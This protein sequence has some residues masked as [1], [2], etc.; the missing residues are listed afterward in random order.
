MKKKI[1]LSL[2]I[3]ALL[4]NL[5]VRVT[6][7]ADQ[8][9]VFYIRHEHIG[10]R[11]ECGGCYTVPHY[12]VHCEPGEG[13]CYDPVYHSHTGSSSRGGGCYTA[14]VP[15]HHSGNSSSGGA[16]YSP[17]YHS[18]G[19]SCYT[20]HWCTV[21][22][23]TQELITTYTGPCGIHGDNATYVKYK[24]LERHYNC[25][26]GDIWSEVDFCSQCGAPGS[27]TSHEYSELI[28]TKGSGT[29]DSYRLSCGHSEGDVDHY[30]I[31]CGLEG[32]IV[33]YTL[34]CTKGA[35]YV[36]CYDRGCGIEEGGNAASVTVT[37]TL[38]SGGEQASLTA[39]VN[40]LT[41]GL[42][43]L[44]NVTLV[45]KDEG[46]NVIGEGL[47]LT[48]DENGTY[49][50]TAE[51]S[52]DGI[53][54]DT[55]SGNVTVSGIEKIVP[56]GPDEGTSGEENTQNGDDNPV[57]D[58]GDDYTGND[59]DT[60]T[61]E[62][63]GN[64][65]GEQND[66]S[67]NEDDEYVLPFPTPTPTATPVVA[68]KPGPGDKGSSHDTNSASKWNNDQGNDNA[69]SLRIGLMS[70]RG[71]ETIKTDGKIRAVK[72]EVPAKTSDASN[73]EGLSADTL[74]DEGAGNGFLGKAGVF[75]RSP[76]GK[77][78]TIGLST[79]LL[80]AALF[81]LLL[82]LRVT[83][84]VFNMDGQMKRHFLGIVFVRPSKEGYLLEIPENISEKAYTNRFEF[85][86]GLFMIGRDSETEVLIVKKDKQ[87]MVRPE[88]MTKVTI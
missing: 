5:P 23:S 26:R 34:T 24:F 25:G 51:A 28:C 61:G 59:D 65:D 58:G 70:D 83:V 10:N 18:H 33:D 15:H 84:P 19:P 16:C 35:D 60:D 86:M 48:V 87:I 30:E 32:T 4:L 78:I 14:A 66:G 85:Y 41:G 80:I 88:R 2:L 81:L 8:Q 1:L 79:A 63:E 67:E 82:L 17:V 46:G 55:Y 52:G 49:T 71:T 20:S 68:S 40:D 12:H 27:T 22:A 54:D 64:G 21:S 38:I 7:F 37:K 76:A 29:I 6:A 45:W 72:K 42:A 9:T 11:D 62:E 13:D 53:E 39:S 56:P 75:L 73:T 77:V 74:N 69:S 43:D 36:D 44:S 47:S 3:T 50:L 31:G 57:Y